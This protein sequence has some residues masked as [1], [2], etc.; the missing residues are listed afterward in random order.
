MKHRIFILFLITT[1]L[2]ACSN[3]ESISDIQTINKA[4]NRQTTGDS[5]N[6]LLSD[7]TFKSLVI[8]LVYVEDFEPTQ[9][10]INN[11]VAFLNNRTYKP[12]GITVEKRSITSPGQDVYTIEEIA[13]IERE[14]RVKYNS[15]NQIAIWA[16]FVDGKSDKDN[17]TDVVLGT[18]YWNTSFVIYQET[19]QE[20]SNSPFEPARE[21]LETSVITHELGHILG[22]TNLG[23]T[24]QTAHED[25][26]HPK[27]CNEPSCL[28]NWTT[29]S[30]IGI[31]NRNTIPQLDSQCL[32]DLRANGGK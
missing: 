4:L 7:T 11:F 3:E 22:L 10:T 13:D 20:L 1:V 17:D 31:T 9:T 29:E 14:Q 28:M 6:D 26:E 30:G 25:E 15:N 27:H 32:A 12:N 5:A 21:T 19:V 24:M 8:E 18:A 16:F 23:S 2:T